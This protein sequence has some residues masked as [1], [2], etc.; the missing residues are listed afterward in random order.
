MSYGTHGME[1]PRI[2]YIYQFSQE[3]EFTLDYF[4]Y[5]DPPIAPAKTGERKPQ[6]TTKTQ[7]PG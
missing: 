4:V 6:E 1:N 5:H 3:N 7:H 2:R